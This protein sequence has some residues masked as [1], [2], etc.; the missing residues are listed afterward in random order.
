MNPTNKRDD[1]DR[2][3]FLSGRC[4]AIIC[5]GKFSLTFISLSKW[6]LPVHRTL[7]PLYHIRSNKS[8]NQWCQWAEQACNRSNKLYWHEWIGAKR[9]TS[10]VSAWR[11]LYNSTN[12]KWSLCIQRN[13]SQFGMNPL[14]ILSSLF[15]WNKWYRCTVKLQLI[16][17]WILYPRGIHFNHSSI[18]KHEVRF[19]EFKR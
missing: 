15:K 7:F 4:D 11:F 6:L 19:K 13:I 12:R 14:V 8:C 10:I 18:S 9:A 3:N 16:F 17:Q 1:D 5:Y 2:M